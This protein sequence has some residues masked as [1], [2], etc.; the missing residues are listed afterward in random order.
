MQLESGG[1]DSVLA[2]AM[3]T[4]YGG[5]GPKE[6]DEFS[7][8]LPGNEAP[9]EA[10][11]VQ[12]STMVGGRVS[13]QQMASGAVR[14]VDTATNEVLTGEAARAAISEAEQ[15]QIDLAGGAAGARAQATR[16]ADI[17]LGREAEAE[18][19][20]GREVGAAQGGRIAG[21]GQA[22]RTA[23]MSL[24]LIK[25]LKADPGLKQIVGNVQ[26]RLPAGIPMLTGGQ[27]GADAAARL[28]QVRGRVF[29]EAFE[30]L[31][32]GGQ[33]TQIEG[34][35]AQAAMARL[36][37]AQSEEAIMEALTEL[38]EI[39]TLA[40]ERAKGN[41]TSGGGGDAVSAIQRKVTDAIRKKGSALTPQE[42]SGLLTPDELNLIMGQ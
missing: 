34:D 33:I 12:S 11:R 32:G 22:E 2:D 24:D 16:E 7:A 38:E 29:L 5:M 28:A 39:Y 8:T 27:A 18:K 15:A 42:L 25:E 35:K 3:V 19:A 21:A 41:A 9:V 23:Q 30:S 17:D 31:K 37:T 6:F 1:A 20:I 36:E 4:L 14:V 10:D 40:V 26:G 13:V